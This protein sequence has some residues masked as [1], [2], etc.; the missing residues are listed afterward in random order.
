MRALE[1][2]HDG[3]G[4]SFSSRQGTSPSSPG[5][6]SLAKADLVVVDVEHL[7]EGQPSAV[8]EKASH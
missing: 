7:G 4:K 6:P 3:D 8:E 5:Q 1:D 2:C